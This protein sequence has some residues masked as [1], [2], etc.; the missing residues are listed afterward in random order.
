MTLKDGVGEVLEAKLHLGQRHL[1]TAPL[2]GMRLSRCFSLRM[3]PGALGVLDV[4]EN[5][6]QLAAWNATALQS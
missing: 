3:P 1:F 4:Y 2:L 6:V 5:G